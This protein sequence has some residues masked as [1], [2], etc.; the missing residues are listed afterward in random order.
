MSHRENPS[1][2]RLLAEWRAIEP[3]RVVIDAIVA[4][5]GL[6]FRDTTA[7]AFARKGAAEAASRTMVSNMKMQLVTE[8]ARELDPVLVAKVGKRLVIVDGHHRLNAYRRARRETIPCRIRKATMREALQVARVTNLDQTKLPMDG[9]QA[10]KCVWQAIG[11]YTA[12]GTRGAGCSARSIART[13]GGVAR[14]TVD[15]MLLRVAAMPAGWEQL[16]RNPISGWPTWAPYGRPYSPQQPANRQIGM[17]D[18]ADA[19]PRPGRH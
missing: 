19:S 16:E 18:V 5:D 13:Y 10:R 4:V 8:P 14:T 6:Q 9:A 3:Q 17:R 7:I 11:E 12:K 2:T 1:E 15:T